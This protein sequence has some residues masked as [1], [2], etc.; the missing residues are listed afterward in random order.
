MPATIK[1]NEKDTV[2]IA[3][4]DLRKGEKVEG[5]VILLED[6]PQAH[7]IALCD[8]EKGAPVIRYGVV[9]GFLTQPI[10]KGEWI[11]EHKMAVAPSPDLASLVWGTDVHVRLPHPR[12][13]TWRGYSVPGQRW[14]GS[15]NILAIPPF[16]TT[17]SLMA[18]PRKRSLPLLFTK[19]ASS[20]RCSM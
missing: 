11:N 7:K 18:L 9:L 15:R 12:R 10:R 1:I 13:T 20:R 3:L 14:A 4:R 5:D 2:A 6:I 8:R 16:V 17:T 19:P